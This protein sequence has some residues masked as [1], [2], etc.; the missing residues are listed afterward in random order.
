MRASM[1]DRVLIVRHERGGRRLEDD[2]AL[3]SCRRARGTSALG[4][5]GQSPSSGSDRDLPAPAGHADGVR[6]AFAS[7]MLAMRVCQPAP[8]SRQ[9]RNTD[10]GRRIVTC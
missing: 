7:R 3:T 4:R 1:H 6:G 5:F 8:L 10:A 2:L 9:R